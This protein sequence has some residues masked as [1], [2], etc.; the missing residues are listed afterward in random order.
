M[1]PPPLDGALVHDPAARHRASV[2]FGHLVH[3]VPHGV[4]H[5]GSADDIAA[6]VRWAAGEGMQVT[7]QGRRHS[8]YGRAQVEH[9]IVVDMSGRTHIHHLDQDRIAL[10]AGATWRDVLTATLPR[11]STPPVLPE[12]LDLSVGG[13]IAAGGIGGTSWR[14]GTLSDNVLALRVVT[15]DG[16]VLT[17]SH[18][19]NAELFDA[20]RAGLGQVGIITQATLKLMP[21]PAAVRRYQLVYP[22]LDTMLTDQRLLLDQGRWHYLQGGIVPGD[23]GGWTYTIDGSTLFSRAAPDD[24]TMLAGLSDDRAAADLGTHDYRAYVDRFTPLEE[25]LRAGGH[26]SCPHP[27]LFT[28]LGSTDVRSILAEE[29][30][31]LTPGDLGTFG[32]VSVFPLRAGAVR[33]PLFRMPAEPVVF[34]LNLMRYA[35]SDSP[36][37]VAAMVKANRIVYERVRSAGGTLNPVSALPMSARDWREHLGTEW[38]RLAAAKDAYDPRHTLTPGYEIF[39]STPEKH[40]RLSQ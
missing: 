10:D 34:A 28:F 40:R 1:K 37:A 35:P 17:C 19:T 6:V 36:A 33:S 21:A 32:R 25:A 20:V 12:Y 29:L 18:D 9:G 27:W 16:R 15:G 14:H 22:D 26:W 8:V 11:G 24:D 2:D 3:K 4:L 30:A 31:G 23:D 39:A 5:P 7:A 13:T 38:D